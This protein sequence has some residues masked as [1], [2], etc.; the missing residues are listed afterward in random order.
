MDEERNRRAPRPL[1]ER[2]DELKMRASRS[3]DR[4]RHFEEDVQTAAEAI[5]GDDDTEGVHDRPDTTHPQVEDVQP[6]DQRAVV[7]P[8]DSHPSDATELPPP[9]V[10]PEEAYRKPP[11]TRNSGNP[12]PADSL[13]VS[14]AMGTLAVDAAPFIN[15]K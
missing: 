8:Q 12:R 15:R 10:P 5:G 11:T 3:K 4:V 6:D 9:P 13:F 1:V 14:G 2:Y 7:G